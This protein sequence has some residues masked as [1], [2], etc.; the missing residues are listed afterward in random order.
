MSSD[1]SDKMST[2]SSDDDVSYVDSYID[3]TRDE[4]SLDTD[5]ES[6][7]SASSTQG[8]GPTDLKDLLK[9]LSVVLHELNT[10]MYK[11]YQLVSRLTFNAYSIR[12]CYTSNFSISSPD[13]RLRFHPQI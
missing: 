12:R 2:V 9:H 10:L 11:L 3:L 6:T 13:S 5:L 1:N 8:V 7:S 4:S